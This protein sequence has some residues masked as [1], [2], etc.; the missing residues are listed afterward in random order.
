[1]ANDTTNIIRT[2]DGSSVAAVV[3]GSAADKTA[4]NSAYTTRALE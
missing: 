1:M 4:D 3:Y 2:L